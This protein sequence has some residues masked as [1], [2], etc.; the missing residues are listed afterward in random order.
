M[1]ITDLRYRVEFDFKRPSN[2]TILGIKES[3]KSALNETL[4][5]KHDKIIDFYG[6]RDDEG[7]CWCLPESP[8]KKILFIHG[9]NTDLKCSHPTKKASAVTLNDLDDHECVIACNSFF[10]SQDVKFSSLQRIVDQIYGRAGWKEENRG[11]M[12]FLIRESMSIIYSR[13][14]QNDTGMKEAKADFLFMQREM[15]HFGVSFGIDHLRWT[16]VDM[17]IRD[18]SDYTFIKQIGYKSLPKDIAFLYNYVDPRAFSQMK[19]WEWVLLKKDGS[20]GFGTNDLPPFHKPEGVNLLNK[21]G[22]EIKHGEEIKESSKQSVGDKE[23]AEIC[24]FYEQGFSMDR[25]SKEKVYRSTETIQR[26]ITE[27]NRD[28]SKPEGCKRCHRVDSDLYNKQLR[29]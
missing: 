14:Q 25:I 5:T 26:H 11:I 28:A 27:H 8:K 17:E 12:Y 3:G 20:I 9:D 16:G 18:L 1:R 21:L 2:Y 6:S 22:I 19:P 23:H 13:L 24:R 15:R 29:T 7:L 10:S 4:A